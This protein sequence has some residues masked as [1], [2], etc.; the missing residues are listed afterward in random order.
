MIKASELKNTAVEP[1]YDVMHKIEAAIIQANKD[2]VSLVNVH[3]PDT[4]DLTAVKQ[5]LKANGFGVTS[6]RESGILASNL[7]RPAKAFVKV[8]W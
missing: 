2:G 8:Y 5:T 1:A 4:V 3:V 6:Y 7:I